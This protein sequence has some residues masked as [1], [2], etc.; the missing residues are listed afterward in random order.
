MFRKNNYLECIAFAIFN[1]NLSWTI[2]TT[3]YLLQ[4]KQLHFNIAELY[5]RK[6][7]KEFE[8]L[9][10]RFENEKS[11]Y[12]SIYNA[13]YIEML[14]MQDQYDLETNHSQNRIK[15]E[16]WNKKI[17]LMLNELNAFASNR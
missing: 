8:E 6:I 16:E 14:K 11:K 15:Q 7:N 13:L 3:K 2:D 17:E 9:K 5:T 4:H 1:K 12:H 10:N